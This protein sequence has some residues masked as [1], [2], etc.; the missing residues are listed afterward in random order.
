MSRT[1]YIPIAFPFIVVFFFLLVILLLLVQIGIISFAF[2]KL[3]FTPVHAFI[4]LFLSLIGS[5]I[6]IPVKEIISEHPVVSGKVIRFYGIRYI[7]PALKIEKKTIIAVNFGGAIIPLFISAYLLFKINII[8]ALIGIFVM[9][10]VAHSLAR[11]VKGLGIAM[12]ALIP[13]LIAALIA[14]IISTE[15]AA[16]LAYVSGTF[17]VLIGADLLNLNKVLELDAP[18]VS[19]GG[20]GTFDGIFLT[21]IISALLA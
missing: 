12:P 5:S 7:I 17:G 20:A 13:P 19:I 15:N 8:N 6:N 9:S 14:L 16:L 2:Y 21:G 1:N 3:G 18:I 4:L 10:M 11:P